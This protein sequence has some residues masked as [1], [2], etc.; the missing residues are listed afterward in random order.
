MSPA[1]IE[2]VQDLKVNHLGGH[3]PRLHTD[4][5]LVALSIC[6]A[7]NPVA[8]IAMQQL[9]RLKGCE[10]HSTVILSQVDENLMKKLG[11]NLT[12]EPVYQSKKLYHKQS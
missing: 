5:A 1:V 8:E 10:A 6:A 2:P 9:E 3:N 11:I 7:T 4:E 12:C